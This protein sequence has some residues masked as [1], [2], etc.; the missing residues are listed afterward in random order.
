ME[1][2]SAAQ[3]GAA[4]LVWKDYAPLLLILSM[5]VMFLPTFS[6]LSQRWSQWTE[7]LSHGYLLIA[8]FLYFTYRALPFAVTKPRGGNW[9]ALTGCLLSSCLWALFALVDI[10][11]LAELSL[12]LLL[13]ASIAAL[14]GWRTAWQ[15]RFLLALPIFS[16]S[17]WDHLNDPLVTLSSLMVGQWVSWI[18]IPAVIDGSSIFIPYGHIMIA[19]GCSGLRYFIIALA[20]AYTISYLNGYSERGYIICLAVAAGLALLTN[21]IRIFT[22]ILIGYA[23]E[24]QSS[25]MAEHD[26]FGWTLFG[27]I[28]LPVLYFAPVHQPAE[29]PSSAQNPLTPAWMATCWLI[30][31]A[32]PAIYWLTPSPEHGTPA[33]G[34][35]PARPSA[36]PSWLNSVN[37]NTNLGAST[38]QHRRLGPVWHSQWVHQRVHKGDK[39]TPYIGELQ[40]Q[41]EWRTV[42]SSVTRITASGQNFTALLTELK[43]RDDFQTLAQLSWYQVGTWQTDSYLTAKLLQIPAV[44]TGHNTFAVNLLRIPCSGNCEASFN[45]LSQTAS[46]LARTSE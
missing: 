28:S 42:R 36:Q 7:G 10:N 45:T 12:L 20:M 21:W 3:S 40:N 5:P 27:A 1:V 17:L 39:L 24:M 23:T 16:I 14:Y 25:L 11:A 37:R 18:D 43:A 33:I 15:H 30:L 19:D 29:A 22:L 46:E 2:N 35:N 9:L 44:L 26:F 6:Y 8:A 13:F 4:K 32:G 38:A 31:M 34:A 41:E